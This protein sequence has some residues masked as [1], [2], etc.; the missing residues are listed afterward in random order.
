MAQ[1]VI[2][3]IRPSGFPHLSVLDDLDFGRMPP[4]KEQITVTLEP[5]DLCIC[6]MSFL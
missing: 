4:G 5:H 3:R 6:V 2:F 1:F